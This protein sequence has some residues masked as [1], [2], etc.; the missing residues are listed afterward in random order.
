M[1]LTS[2]TQNLLVDLQ[3]IMAVNEDEII[4]RGIAQATTDR[5][6]ELRQRAGQLTERYGSIEKLEAQGKNVSAD[7][8]T[9]YTDLLDWRSVRHELEQLTHFLSGVEKKNKEQIL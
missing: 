6:I 8:H 5:I 1:V 7:N 9:L 3:K 4:Q 2:R